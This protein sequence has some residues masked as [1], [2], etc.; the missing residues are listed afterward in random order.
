MSLY[1][2]LY[3]QKRAAKLADAKWAAEEALMR[4]PSPTAATNLGSRATA[5]GRSKTPTVVRQRVTTTV[6]VTARS[7]IRSTQTPATTAPHLDHRRA[8]SHTG[9][10]RRDCSVK[11]HHGC[12]ADQRSIDD[13]D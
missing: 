1:D 4:K 7:T 5:F 9:D 12:H 10:E 3:H 11:S 6:P 8:A 13:H 2:P